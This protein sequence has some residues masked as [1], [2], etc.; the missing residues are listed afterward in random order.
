MTANH[1]DLW[2][3]GCLLLP[4]VD[5]QTTDADRAAY[6]DYHHRKSTHFGQL[7]VNCFHSQLKSVRVLRQLCGQK[8]RFPCPWRQAHQQ[9]NESISRRQLI[10]HARQLN[11]TIISNIF[12]GREWGRGM[13]N[14]FVILM[15]WFN[16]ITI[17]NQPIMVRYIMLR[18]S[19]FHDKIS[20]S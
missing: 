14:S 8:L 12:R 18:L 1:D 4:E 3:S 17:S 2:R 10:L 11:V 7:L 13:R 19:K 16:V 5:I 9:N 6:D 20:W 15:R